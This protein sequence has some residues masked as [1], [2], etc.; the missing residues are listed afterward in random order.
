MRSFY[1]I[2]VMIARGI[3]ESVM[4]AGRISQ[5]SCRS[6]LSPPLW[7]SAGGLPFSSPAYPAFGLLSCP[8][9]PSPLPRWGR[10]SFKVILCKGLRPRHPCIRPL[11]ALTV[12]AAQVPSGV[13][14]A[15]GRLPTLPFRHPQGGLPP[16][17]LARPAAVVPGG[18]LAFFV[19][20][21]TCLWFTF[22]P[23]IPPTPFPAGEGGESK[24]S[25]AR[26]FA[27]CIPGAEPAR[28]WLALPI[29]HPAG[30]CLRNLQPGAKPK[31]PL[32]YEQCRQPRRGGDRGRWN[33]PSQATAAFEMV[34]SP[35]AGKPSAARGAATPP[36]PAGYLLGRFCKCRKRLNAGVPGAKPP[37]K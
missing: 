23:P 4:I 20:C 37:A 26:G 9:P 3:S 27:P 28:H 32:S 31:E 35:G 15:G 7:C 22:L 29:R 1:H 36:A 10:G 8:H 21:L 12:P 19:A 24:F 11:A 33:Y 18:G 14:Q 17:A 2:S 13:A 30:V 5:S 6:R 16:A 25:Y 34:L